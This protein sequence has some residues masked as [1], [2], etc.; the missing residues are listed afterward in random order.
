MNSKTIIPG[1][2]VAFLAV[3]FIPVQVSAQLLPDGTFFEGFDDSTYMDASATTAAWW[4]LGSELRIFQSSK[5]L[6]G[7][8][9]YGGTVKDVEVAGDYAYAAEDGVG[10][11]VYDLSVETNINP[12][13]VVSTSGSAEALQVLGDFAYMADGAAGLQV[14]GIA[15]SASPSL[16]KT[17]ALDGDA[18]DVAVVG[19]LA[20]VAS[21]TQGMH[22]IDINYPPSAGQVG[23]FAGINGA[24]GIDVQDGYAYITDHDSGYVWVINISNPAAM[25]MSG[26]YNTGKHPA[27]IDVQGDLAYVAMELDGM[28]ILDVSNPANPVLVTD[29]D[30]IPV[31]DITVEGGWAFFPASS[32]KFAMM[33][34]QDPTNPIH[35]GAQPTAG[36][37]LA[38]KVAGE[39]VLVAA[40]TDGVQ[41]WDIADL[42]TPV[43]VG[44][45]AG[46]AYAKDIVVQGRKAYLVDQ[47]VGL[48]I[49]D[50]TDPENPVAQGAL[51]GFP[52]C[53]S[54][55]VDGDLVALAHQ[56]GGVSTV[57]VS[58][59]LNPV[60]LDTSIDAYGTDM[61]PND[62]V[63]DGNILHVAGSGT[64]YSMKDITDPANISD[65]G[66]LGFGEGLGLE[67]DGD[68]GTMIKGTGAVTILDWSWAGSPD[69]PNTVPS[70][71]ARDVVMDGNTIYIANGNSGIM[72]VDITDLGNTV[73]MMNVNTSGPANRVAVAGDYL[74]V[75]E[76]ASG[77]E[78]FDIS[79]PTDPFPVHHYWSPDPIEALTVVGDYCYMAA[80][81]GGLQVL[82]VFQRSWDQDL[83][84]GQSTIF[85][86]EDHN[87][88]QARV[89]TTEN[90]KITWLVSSLGGMEWVNVPSDGTWT[91]INYF[92]GRE[93]AWKAL[94]SVV[95]PRHYPVCDDLQI[96]W[97]LDTPLVTAI[98]DV[99]NDQGRQ[100]SL[101]WRRS[102]HDVADGYKPI[103]EY[104]VYRKIEGSV[105]KAGVD[106]TDKSYPPG[107]W[108]YLMTVPADWE[109][110]Y[111][112]VVPT[113]GD[114]TITD[115]KYMS[116]YF[117]RARTAIPGVYF[118]A[119]P[120]SG[121]SVDNLEP[122]VPTGLK[123]QEPSVLAWDDP[124][125][126][127]F[128][129]FTIYG[130]SSPVFDGSAVVIGQTT[131]TSL[132]ITGQ[133]P[134]YYFLTATDFSGNESEAADLD[135]VSNIPGVEVRRFALH[136]NH[137]NPFNPRTTITFELPSESP[138]DLVIFDLSGRLVKTLI[139][140]RVLGSG[141][142]EAVWDGRDD[143]GRQAA[144]GVY[145]FR[146]VAGSHRETR[147]MSLVK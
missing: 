91:T 57:D 5:E 3:L 77:V 7:N 29:V 80:G 95:K 85:A 58:D 104:A 146:L 138:A 124:L 105:A 66:G 49:Y 87:V 75:G 47:G 16:R 27:K 24:W 125:D 84:V 17:V 74:F 71:D 107:D 64:T 120:D 2:L 31:M 114:S 136:P 35:W 127:D 65:G 111:S 142:H 42:L 78:V 50:I 137:P 134:A 61:I 62:V 8:E 33:D 37:P 139:N 36:T 45:S 46:V 147:R 135:L 144:A 83:N 19:N 30:W 89:T 130:S 118:D 116:T 117:V 41:L 32:D 68:L 60:L 110:Q 18:M 113:L 79:D 73:I 55:D 14:I 56:A 82:G 76:G 69:T 22:V 115:G 21:Y 39:K 63:L 13:G 59:P 93:L 67:V 20:F 6:I 103:V 141:E 11:V 12:V 121:Y 112:V 9:G 123:L 92:Q 94:L 23:F 34:V 132:D 90:E 140:G 26:Y 143:G 86:T 88:V 53:V 51:G 101:T 129:Y 70:N 97:M 128:S 98:S 122:A 106:G 119:A 1:I 108:H 25:V 44:G 102:G 145:L 15:S 131:G 100:V 133:D 126:N 109:D 40:G 10:L 99:G 38:V 54:I 96:D 81:G 28:L 43:P 72:V 52:G 48:R 4:T